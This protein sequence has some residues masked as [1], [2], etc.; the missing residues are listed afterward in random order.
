M[1]EAATTTVRF[2]R[3]GARAAVLHSPIAEAMQVE[4]DPAAVY[5][6]IIADCTARYV[7]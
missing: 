5:Y 2:Q 4:E 3:V 6:G 1:A 7:E